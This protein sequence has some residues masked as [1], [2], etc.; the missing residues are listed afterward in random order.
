MIGMMRDY[1]LA[2]GFFAVIL[3]CA[4]IL[5][6][7]LR[8]KHQS[9]KRI[10]FLIITAAILSLEALR[11]IM[12]LARGYTPD[13]LPLYL[14]SLYMP[15]FAM[16]SFGKSGG[17]LSNIG[18]SLSLTIGLPIAI[19]TILAP[20]VVFDVLVYGSATQNIFTANAV[21]RHY[22]S[23][24]YHMLGVFFVTLCVVLKPYKPK[25]NDAILA[26]G[27]F[28]SFVLV[29]AFV[30]RYVH[31]DYIRVW[32]FPLSIPVPILIMLYQVIPLT[33]YLLSRM[34][35]ADTKKTEMA[36]MFNLQR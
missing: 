4:Y 30:S 36:G 25:K 13:N 1:I 8:E 3:A 6:K 12:A 32:S 19:S 16:A 27:V 33:G 18:Y 35:F 14:C 29:S 24:F 26:I 7:K 21:F 10:P 2:L 31:V 20:F 28:L 5:H 17:K 11:Q 34:L 23:F 9:A 22:H 15:V